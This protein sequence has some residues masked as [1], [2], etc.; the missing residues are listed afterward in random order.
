MN[1]FQIVK[2]QLLPLFKGLPFILVMLLLALFIARKV[3]MYTPSMYQSIARIKLD[4]QKY[5][6]SNNLL[7]SDFDLF[8]TENKVQA[9]AAVLKSTLLV[10]MT[11]DRLEMKQSL[12]RKGKIKN[13]L[14]YDDAPILV[15]YSVYE[16]SF[17]DRDYF[18]KVVDEYSYQIVDEKGSYMGYS[19]TP[20]GEPTIL[21]EG[22]LIITKNDALLIKNNYNLIGDYILHVFS[23]DRLIE[24]VIS[25]LDVSETDKEMPIIRVVYKDQHP[26][27]VA[28]VAN[29]LCDTYINDYVAAKTNAA[30]QTVDFIN[31]KLEDVLVELQNSEIAL[32]Q[33]KAENG[34]VNT[35]QETETG[36]RKISD[37]EVQLVNLEMNEKAILE[38]EEYI[39]SGDYFNERAINFGFGDLLMTELV[40]RLKL[41]Q[42]ERIDL[43]LKYTENSDEVKAVNQKID[44]VKV[45][46]V[47]AINRNK[48]EILTKREEI[49]KSVELAF[50]QFEGLSTREKEM[51]I[52]ERNFHLQEQVYNFLSQKK[53]EASIASSVRIAFH[54]IIQKAIVPNEPVSP[55]SIL[56]TFIAGLLALI[57]GIT[58]VYFRKGALARVT[59]RHDIERNSSLP[60]LS[61]VRAGNSIEDMYTLAKSLHLKSYF[62]SPV[63]IAIT[64]TVDK[65]GKSFIAENLVQVLRDAG[66]KV[67]L[68]HLNTLEK[69]SKYSDEQGLLE[70]EATLWSKQFNLSEKIEE[71]KNECD[72]VVIDSPASAIH[73]GGVESLKVADVGL[74]IVRAYHTSM[75]YLNNADDLAEEYK[76]N[77]LFLVLND[78]HKASNFNGNFIGARFSE[79]V[80]RLRFFPRLIRYLNIYIR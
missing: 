68:V 52:L 20:F 50:M 8:S 18:I 78:A 11:V 41:W 56:I 59:D 40:K 2:R 33:Y 27:K 21:T 3:V 1:N 57:L 62:N 14:L 22:A 37:L 24:D 70:D 67:I 79:S 30:Q 31:Y 49:E 34:V 66:K 48:S 46:I 47:E 53:I 77:N 69:E 35:R 16:N 6:F 12:Y 51:R 74:Y 39:S 72:V 75:S 64:S 5:G 58:F 54:R 4:D 32:E 61:L 73:V 7:Y 10:G 38:L 9:E 63:S 44:E 23:R 15:E 65:E 80:Q 43:L 45:Y 60:L 26:Q 71:L 55:N 76:L 29:A 19:K 25:R 28:D 17:L 36:L 13:A 42:D